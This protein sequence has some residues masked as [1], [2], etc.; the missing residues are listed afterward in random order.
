MIAQTDLFGA[1]PAGPRKPLTLAAPPARPPMPEIY[2]PAPT[3]EWRRMLEA[4]GEINTYVTISLRWTGV[5]VECLSRRRHGRWILKT[6]GTIADIAVDPGQAT[7]MVY[8]DRDRA[9]QIHAERP[10]IAAVIGT[11]AITY[12]FADEGEDAPTI[13]PLPVGDLDVE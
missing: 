6:D 12:R 4:A 8:V 9:L 1:L 13:L 2:P 7:R 10:L 3:A 11:H 5:V